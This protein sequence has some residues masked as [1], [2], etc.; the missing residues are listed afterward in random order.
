[1]KANHIVVNPK[2]LKK[3]HQVNGENKEYDAAPFFVTTLWEAISNTQYTLTNPKM[4][5]IFVQ[6]EIL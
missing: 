6:Q 3:V 5:T 2:V 4:T 1:M